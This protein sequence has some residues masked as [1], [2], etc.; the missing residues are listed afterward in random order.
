MKLNPR[1]PINSPAWYGKVHQLRLVCLHQ[2]SWHV[3]VLEG[4][5]DL[6]S[7]IA[8]RTEASLPQMR[9]LFTYSTVKIWPHGC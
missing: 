1:D 9:L 2:G 3:A 6:Y 8:V 7:F 4:L 5:D